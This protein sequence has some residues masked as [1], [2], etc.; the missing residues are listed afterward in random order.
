[1]KK[2]KK[3]HT[4]KFLDGSQHARGAIGRNESQ[5]PQ[6]AKTSKYN[7]LGARLKAF[8]TDMFLLNMPILYITTYVFLQG[9][10]DFLGNQLAIFACEMLYCC[11]LFLFFV[12]KGQTP[13]FRYAEIM[14]SSADNPGMPPRAWQVALF[15]VVWLFELCFFL[16]IVALLRKDKK[17]LHELASNTQIIYKENPARKAYLDGKKMYD[18]HKK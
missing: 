6:A 12:W 2:H 4:N 5:A 15:L 17:T 3:K 13:G 14:L 16:W 10:E 9:K 1:M 18:E 8:L 7:F 11:V